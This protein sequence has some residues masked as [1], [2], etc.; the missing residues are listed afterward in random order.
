MKKIP[1]HKSVKLSQ[2]LAGQRELI[3]EMKNKINEIVE[4]ANFIDDKLFPGGLKIQEERH[5]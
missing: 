5:I 2:T 4:W 3:R 1:N